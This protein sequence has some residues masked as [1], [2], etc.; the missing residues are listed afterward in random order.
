MFKPATLTGAYLSSK[1]LSYLALVRLYI[2]ISFI[3]FF[4]I[5][6]FPNNDD[7]SISSSEEKVIENSL[8]EEITQNRKLLSLELSLIR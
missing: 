3:T 7:V 2:F 6:V 5:T 4:L 8:K 1:R